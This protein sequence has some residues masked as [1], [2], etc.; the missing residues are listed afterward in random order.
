L[1]TGF[2]L[3]EC[4]FS[5]ITAMAATSEHS[6]VREIGRPF[7]AESFIFPKQ[8]ES[9]FYKT[10]V[11]CADMA[12]QIVIERMSSVAMSLSVRKGPWKFSILL[13]GLD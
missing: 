4:L 1:C 5:A 8:K 6:T 10:E 9:F 2:V 13:R 3:G 7:G 11:L 12:S